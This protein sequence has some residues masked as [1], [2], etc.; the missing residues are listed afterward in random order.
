M[1]T[2][3]YIVLFAVALWVYA[4]F[5]VLTNEFS[6]SANKI[7]WIILLIFLPLSAILYPFIGVKQIKNA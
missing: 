7:I 2:I 3:T 4:F 5:S 1:D 6:N